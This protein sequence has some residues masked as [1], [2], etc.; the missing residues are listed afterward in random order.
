[1]A[2]REV[3]LLSDDEV[4]GPLEADDSARPLLLSD[5]DVFGPAPDVTVGGQAK[6]VATNVPRMLGESVGGVLQRAG[7]ADP[8]ADGAAALKRFENAEGFVDKLFAAGEVAASVPGALARMAQTAAAPGL[9]PAREA[10]KKAL[11]DTGVRTADYWHEGQVEIP[12]PETFAEDPVRSATGFVAEAAQGVAPSLA[13]GAAVTALTRS[14]AA[15]AVAIV[16]YVI[17]QEYA[18]RRREGADPESARIEAA[19]AAA[20]E[21][22]PEAR[23]LS[24]ITA[25]AV[26]VVS[27]LLRG[28]SEEAWQEAQTQ[29]IQDS[30]DHPDWTLEQ[31]VKSAVYAAGLGAVGGGVVGAVTPT[32]RAETPPTDFD[33]T[34]EYDVTRQKVRAAGDQARAAVETL[35]ALPAPEK[36]T[37]EV[38]SQG[39]ATPTDL[40]AQKA[41][42]AEQAARAAEAAGDTEAAIALRRDAMGLTPQ[43]ADAPEGAAVEIVP[44]QVELAPAPP[45]TELEQATEALTGAIRPAAPATNVEI[46]T[47][48]VETVEAAPAPAQQPDTFTSELPTSEGIEA[49]SPEVEAINL[50]AVEQARARERMA[51]RLPEGLKDDPRLARETFRNHLQAMAGE[52]MKGQSRNAVVDDFGQIVKRLPSGNPQWFQDKV[53]GTLSTSAIKEAVRKALAGEKLSKAEATG[54]RGMLDYIQQQRTTETEIETAR[55][56][57]AQAQ[58]FRRQAA[59]GLPPLDA[60]EA[61]AEMAGELYEEAEY[62]PTWDGESR[63]LFELYEAAAEVDEAAALETLESGLEDA[64]AA[65]RFAEIIHGRET[66]RSSQEDRGQPREGSQ[67]EAETAEAP[68]EEPEVAPPV[69]NTYSREDLEDREREKASA[70]AQ[71]EA[72][73]QKA[74]ADAQ[75]DTFALTGSDRMADEAAARGQQDLLALPENP[76]S[77]ELPIFT[78]RADDS[79]EGWGAT[80]GSLSEGTKQTLL[81]DSEGNYFWGDRG[82]A[83]QR[84]VGRVVV[85]RHKDFQPAK[86]ATTA[87]ARAAAKSTTATEPRSSAPKGDAPVAIPPAFAR[88]V[89]VKVDQMVEGEGIRSVEVSA[90]EALRDVKREISVFQKLLKCVSR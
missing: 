70:A 55:Q 75:R 17:G 40:R 11:A 52:V 18:K 80:R 74:D 78:G 72:D 89:K 23:V 45:Q 90:A 83:S 62:D 36:A 21:V 49:T 64:Q 61:D 76:S 28:A 77:S 19:L 39:I 29:V 53:A 81:V 43:P 54:V 85:G 50:D 58:A 34:A 2:A 84:D 4:F 66:G 15:G 14:P 68:R 30:L 71:R 65:R 16:P 69:L 24:T 56:R 42:A 51:A 57:R 20:A 26:G 60:Y 48:P 41:A 35:K 47:V 31:R 8:L 67:A 12:K 10:A 38:D 32:S 27:K 5:D 73:Q 79:G 63:S 88:R 59:Q 1:M 25:P 46:D 9:E 82:L 7:E 13:A 22:I 37:I 6:A 86:F 87:E 3:T 44:E 33:P